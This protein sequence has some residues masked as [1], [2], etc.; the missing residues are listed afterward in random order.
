[1]PRKVHHGS[2]YLLILYSLRVRVRKNQ[3]GHRSSHRLESTRRNHVSQGFAHGGG[4]AVRTCLVLVWE[5]SEQR[6]SPRSC[7]AP[8]WR[9]RLHCCVA[10]QGYTFIE[11][12][13][14]N[15][16]V[17]SGFYPI[18]GVSAIDLQ[19]EP[20]CL[21][22]NPFD[23]LVVY[24]TQTALDAVA[25]AHQ[26]P[27]VERL[28]WPLGTFDPVVYQL[29]KTLLSSL[30]LPHHTSKIFL[31]Y[32]LHALNCHF[33]CSYSG[34]T[35][36]A[37]QFRGWTLFSADAKSNRVIGCSSGR[38]Y[39]PPAGRRSMRFISKPLCAGL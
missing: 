4:Q 14:G 2:V 19:E 27:P 28:V 29:G 8:R 10:I 17:S 25:Y 37:T 24:V 18:G 23:A 1:M 5:V 34:V 39:C 21:L 9:A 3:Y 31:D 16:K 35:N 38:Q 11:Q 6:R 12:F 22:P 13:L 7:T 30:E 36:S 26:A 32:V 33:V 15:K 20:A